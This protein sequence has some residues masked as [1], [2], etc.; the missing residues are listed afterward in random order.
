MRHPEIYRPTSHLATSH[1]YLVGLLLTG[2]CLIAAPSWA[3]IRIDIT[4][5]DPELS[6]NVRNH[7]G[8]I[9]D[10]EVA[11]PR[12]LRQ[13]LRQIIPLA[14]EALGYYGTHF[15]LKID[16]KTVVIQ[17]KPGEP[18]R[19]LSPNLQVD[20]EAAELEAVQTKLKNVPITAG[21][22]I[23]HGDYDRFKRELLETC[24]EYGF[25]DARYEAGTLA[26]DIEAHQATATL[27][28]DC[29]QRYHFGAIQF[30]DSQL[31]YDLLQR[32]VPIAPDEPY[33]KHKI[34]ELYRNLQNS[35]Y[36]GD[37]DIETTP[38]ASTHAVAVSVKTKDAPRHQLSIGL[39]YGT[40]TGP[41]LKFRWE[42]PLVN[43]AGHS[44]SVETSISQ[45]IQNLTADYRIPLQRP[46]DQ[47][48]DVPTTFE[49][50]IVE[51][52]DST[53]GKVGLFYNDRYDDT[54][55]GSYGANIEVESYQ[56]GSAPR[57]TQR[58]L[59][60]GTTFTDLV[61][62][63]GVDPLWGHKAWVAAAGSL[64]QLGADSA[65]L[66]VDAGYKRLINTFGSQ[67]LVARVEVG[68]I[69]TDDINNIPS[70]Q[71]FFT[72]GDATVRGFDYESLAPADA[73]GKLVGGRFLNVGSVD[74]S[75]KVRESWRAA[76]F[77]DAG[78]AFDTVGDPWHKAA[79]VGVR[80]LSPVGQIRIDLAFPLNEVERSWRLHIFMGPP[81]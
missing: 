14:T 46:L 58:Y 64:P 65:F 37:I 21:A 12:K 80:W 19:W 62:P 56:Q 13:R 79:G 73:T 63:E 31:N 27:H 72:G 57:Q 23:N 77:I 29:G 78:R 4:G 38:D 81:L 52:T 17:L 44:F 30:A 6:N 61:L 28:L 25:L 18:V 70:S 66:R 41:R 71:R 49:R 24:L 3:Q 60:P 7:I 67:L 15:D 32:L 74:Y 22:V 20:G 39:G 75:V 47:Y 5:A 55:R 69:A 34:S 53:L 51:D 2:L 8:V 50:K 11:H 42:R 48:L 45:P 68:A 1:R 43:S 10:D 59:V 35:H 36:F 16:D 40:D 54:W 33:R 9:A 76:V 26:V